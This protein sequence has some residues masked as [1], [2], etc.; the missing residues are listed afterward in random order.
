MKIPL[1][2]SGIGL[3]SSLLFAS[4]GANVI[5]VDINITAAEKVAS[6]IE[7]EYGGQLGVEAIAIKADVS[8]EKEVKATV[9]L[10]VEKYGRLDVIVSIIQ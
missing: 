1:T 7:K 6:I 2:I 8:N 4:E 9:D 10:A 3:E 5:L